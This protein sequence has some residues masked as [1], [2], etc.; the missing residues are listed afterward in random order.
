MVGLH[1]CDEVFRRRM[2]FLGR[3]KYLGR[4]APGGNKSRAA[5]LFL[6]LGD[7]FLDLQGEVVLRLPF[8]DVPA[9]EIFHV[10]LIES[11]FHGLDLGKERLDQVEMVLVENAGVQRGFEG[12]VGNWVPAAENEVR[13]LFERHEVPNK[14]GAALGAFAQANCAQL[15]KRADRL[16]FAAADEFDSGHERRAHGAHAWHQDA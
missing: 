5:V 4:A 13:Q 12:I 11:R 9:A 8:L 14:G 1:G 15:R 2:N 6:E 16:G 7:V 3:E 10:L